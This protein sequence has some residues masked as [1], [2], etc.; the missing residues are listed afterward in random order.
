MWPIGLAFLLFGLL[1][2]TDTTLG[3]HRGNASASW[4]TTLG[5]VL[6]SQVRK[7]WSPRGG[8]SYEPQVTYEYTVDGGPPLRGT[9]IRF[10][11]TD[12]SVER[13]THQ[14]IARYPVGATVPVHY[15][16]HN[17]QHTTLEPS[18]RHRARVIIGAIAG[19]A[20]AI[21]GVAFIAL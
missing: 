16:P 21:A 20:S 10:G 1:V 9:T 12:Y 2:L 19:L 6:S 18:V 5:T 7:S 3:L 11:A 17:P 14:V 15:D 13:D 8:W 4:P